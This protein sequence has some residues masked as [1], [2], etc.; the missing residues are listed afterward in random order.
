MK[1]EKRMKYVPLVNHLRRTTRKWV[2][3]IPMVIGAT[4]VVSKD[5]TEAVKRLEL[6]LDIG[7]LQKIAAVQTC[8]MFRQLL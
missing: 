6:D 5:T 7:W 2:D 8:N 1:S 4:G 3:F